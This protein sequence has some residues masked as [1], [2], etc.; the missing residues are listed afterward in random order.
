MQLSKLYSQ[1]TIKKQIE[2]LK[3]NEKIITNDY[4][5]DNLLQD[6]IFE[7][8]DNGQ[9]NFKKFITIHN[10][11]RVGLLDQYIGFLK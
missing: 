1:E 5:L 7:Q 2:K 3:N 11:N 10:P 6:A 8:I 9:E 4:E